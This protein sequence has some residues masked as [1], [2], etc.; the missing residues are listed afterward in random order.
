[1]SGGDRNNSTLC[2]AHK[3]RGPSYLADKKKVLADEPLFALA[4]VDLLELDAP[5]HHIARY[6]PSLK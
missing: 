5:T 1:M 4:A 3:V 2:F 6:L